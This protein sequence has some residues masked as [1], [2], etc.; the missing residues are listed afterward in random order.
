MSVRALGTIIEWDSEQ[1]LGKTEFYSGLLD[2][3][4]WWT[5]DL[6]STTIFCR[7]PR[8]PLDMIS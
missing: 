1:P 5:H 3:F 4:D 7:L 2:Y 6:A 8:S